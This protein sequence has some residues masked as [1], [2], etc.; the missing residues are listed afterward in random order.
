MNQLEAI[1]QKLEVINLQLSKKKETSRKLLHATMI[2][3]C[4]VLLLIFTLLLMINGSYL[5]WDYNNPEL[6]AAGVLIHG[7][8]WI[9]IRVLPIALIALIVEIILTRKKGCR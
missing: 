2:A 5:N 6:A 4:I 3:L 1:S 7:F 9:F 8:E